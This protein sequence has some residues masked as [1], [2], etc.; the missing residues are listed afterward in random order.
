VLW[1]YT[2]PR[3]I[4]GRGL[5]YWPGN[6]TAGPRLYFATDQGDLPATLIWNLL[7]HFA[8]R[9]GAGNSKPFPVPHSLRETSKDVFD[10]KLHDPG[11]TG[12]RDLPE[13]GAVHGSPG[14]SV[15]CAIQNVERF[16]PEF[17]A[18]LLPHSEGP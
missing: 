7:F 5:A 17:K 8:A 6:A 1:Q 14:I 15:V 9:S 18:L 2:S 12:R 3:P 16:R 4:H 10:G 13:Q 11:V